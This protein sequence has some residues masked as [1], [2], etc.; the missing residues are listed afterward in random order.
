MI[1]I[2]RL[3]HRIIG[4]FRLAITPV[5]TTTPPSAAGGV[6]DRAG[7]ALDPVG[8]TNLIN[9]LKT[10]AAPAFGNWVLTRVPA[11]L[12]A[13]TYTGL[14]MVSGW[15]RREQTAAYTDSTDTATNIVNAIPGAQVG[16]TFAFLLANM[17]VGTATLAA[18]TGVTLVGSAVVSGLS[19]R[20]FQGLVTGSAAVTITN[21][22]QFN[23]GGSTAAL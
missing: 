18:G 13:R 14:E 16:Q 4:F 9:D 10:N 15:I 3:A 20:L 8:V 17:S 19:A 5:K 6:Q 11:G 12:A 21:F 1:Y 7:A 22:F 23:C 2:A